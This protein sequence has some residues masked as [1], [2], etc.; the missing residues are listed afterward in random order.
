MIAF[1]ARLKRGAIFAAAASAVLIGVAACSSPSAPASPSTGA[2]GAANKVET[3]NLVTTKYDAE[4]LPVTAAQQQGFFTKHGVDLQMTK[5]S[6]SD[7]AAAALVSGREDLGIVQGAYVVSAAAAGAKIQMVGAL[8]DQ[9]DYHIITTKD[10]KSLKQLQG[11]TMGDPGPSNGNTATMK[12]VMDKAGFKAESLTYATVGTQQAILAALQANQVQVGLL[13]A[14]YTIQAR[15]AGLNDLGSVVKYVPD[16][17]AAAFAGVPDQMKK[18][19][20]LI[21]NFMAALVEGSQ[22]ASKNKD[23]AI[24]MLEKGSG[25]TKD[26]ATQSYAEAAPYYTKTG[27]LDNA[28][29]KGWITDAVKYG[30]Q[31]NSVPVSTVYTDAYLSK[32]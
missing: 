15:Q 25:M 3:L 14:P 28:G 27:H 23:K 5:A 10:I 12:A 11:K 21:K 29:L 16:M 13:V 1:T 31:T 22:W 7:I 9:L 19:S 20:A 18:K 6:T 24:A 32:D 4:L 8:M 17:S 2:S 26:L 30:A